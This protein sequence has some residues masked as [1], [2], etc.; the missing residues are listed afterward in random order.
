MEI[1]KLLFSFVVCYSFFNVSTPLNAQSDPVNPTAA[2]T[3]FNVFTSGDAI[4][5]KTESE[6]SWAVGG[7]LTL[8]GTL[9][10]FGGNTYYN[11]DSQPTALVVNGK[12]NYV[13]GRLQV[14]ENNYIKI[15]DLSTSTI[16]EVDQ[17]NVIS[18]TRITPLGGHFD[19]TPSIA[20]STPQSSTSIA[21]DPQID[22]TAAFN[23]FTAVSDY[24]STLS[25][26]VSWNSNE[27]SQGKLWVDL[28]PNATNVINL[29]VDE[30]NGFSEIK[31]NGLVPSETTPFIV[32]I[33]AV[34]SDSDV[35]TLHS[36]PNIVGGPLSYAPYILYNFA[37]VSS[38]LNYTGGAQIYG[39]IY[40]PNAQF[41]NRSNFNIDGQIIVE[42]FEQNSG[43]VH[44]YLFD[45]TID[46]PPTSSEELCDG[47]DNNGD[48]VI[49]EGFADTDGDGVADCV[50]NCPEVANADQADL[51]GNGIGDVCDEPEIE[52]VCDGIDNNGDGV[53]DEGFADTDGDGVADCVDNCPEVANADQADLDGNG[54]G[55]VCD[56]AEIEEICDGIDN[57]GD[58]V[59]D[60]GFAD[61][62]GDGVADC[63]DNCPEVANADQA[64]LDGNGIGDVCDEP[65]IEEV[66]DGIDNNG[67]GVIDEGFA[68][69]DGD[70]VADCVDNCP[71]VANA[72]Q[73]DLDGNGIGDVCDEVEIE[74][75]CDGI[76]NNGD[77]VIDEGFADTDGD[78]VADCVDN[79]PEVANADQA[80]L[81][82]NGIG[83]VC[84][85][86]EIEE[87]CDGIDNNGDGV[88]DEGFTDTDGDGVADCVD[89]CI[90]AY[91]PDQTDSDGNGLGDACDGSA[92]SGPFY[93]SNFELETYPVPFNGTLNLKYS[94]TLDANATIE[95]VD[96]SGRLLKRLTHTVSKD[97]DNSVITVDL[98]TVSQNNKILFIR[99]ITSEGTIVKRVMSK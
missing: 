84:D 23:Q 96:I 4:A 9:N 45:A 76:D 85:E 12:V 30:F 90:Y 19:S 22:F 60:E 65:E 51:D 33:T 6:G 10:I 42:A 8:D 44:P 40:A 15:G 59:I 57:N 73:A 2:A 54:I 89:N 13:S 77:G 41:N 88:I 93:R 26:N 83:D 43:E 53:I 74:E 3:N 36:W 69:T 72:D 11:G 94:T 97:D 99:F 98:S 70:G 39:T 64:D 71:E 66:C 92:A 55:D 75:V 78:G 87:V 14:L 61:I 95:V 52:E 34:S 18:N 62:D 68:D 21:A 35:V 47:I 27:F 63:V 49:D 24:L 5:I 28:I 67:D 56:E 86:P 48:G 91:N 81:D 16:F 80:D 29:T 82:G 20:L 46:F 37:D 32:N 7:N 38:T 50:D 58:G 79:C 1:K 25:T 17:N 31:F